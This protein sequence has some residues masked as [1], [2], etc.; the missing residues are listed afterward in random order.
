VVGAGPAG[1]EAARVLAERGHEVVLFEAAAEPGGQVTLASFAPRRRDLVGIIDWRVD[2]C[3]RLG[4][5]LRFG[6]YAERHDVLAENPHIV[7]IATGGLP[8]RDILSFGTD[9][10]HDTW[11]VL[12]RT[13]QLNGDVL[14]YD[15]NGSYP[16]LDAAEVL[17]RCGARVAYLSPERTFA[18]DLG[19]V[20]YPGYLEQFGRYGVSITLNMRL[21]GVK[22][23]DGRL[24][25]HLLDEYA[26]QPADRVVDHVVVEHGT[27][28]MADLYF[29]LQSASVNHGEVDLDALVAVRPQR[30]RR[31]ESGSYQLFRVGDAVASRNVHAAMLDA[32]RL[33]L[34]L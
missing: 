8:N 30:I 6:V 21:V 23:G 15:D 33:C 27:A 3:K 29:E 17:A 16:A 22:R 26:E 5:D 20:T 34:V 14:V 12:S 4:V 1:L 31:N 25:A 18:P 10:V 9:L 19:S 24:V 28:P 2:E 13:V 32:Y 7:V 11:D